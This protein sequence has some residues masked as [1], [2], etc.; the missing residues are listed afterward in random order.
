MNNITYFKTSFFK[1][2][3][4]ILFNR[5][6]FLLQNSGTGYNATSVKTLTEFLTSC[7][8]QLK[9]EDNLFWVSL[10]SNVLADLSDVEK[11]FEN[12]LQEMKE[13]MKE[14]GWILPTLEA[15]MR[16]QVNI[17]NVQIEK[18][19]RYVGEMQASITKLKSGTSLIGEIPILFKVNDWNKKKDKV[20]Q[21][22]IELMSQKSEKN[23]VVLW[24]SPTFEDVANDIKKVIKDKEVVAYPSKKSKEEGISNVQ[25]FIEKIDHIL[26]TRN[27]YFNG[28]ES[29]NVIFLTRGFEGVRNSVLRGVQ[30]IICIQLTFGDYDAKMNGMKEDNRFLSESESE[31]ESYE[32]ESDSV[33]DL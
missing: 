12:A 7:R 5:K 14:N 27:K 8:Q 15:N 19:D 28:C 13:E 33:G 2:Y 1:T 9:H 21:H 11:D 24:D 32:S 6:S 26:V 29:A 31:S 16:N 3:I 23:I 18:S 22:C 10:Q 30:N 25:Q 4:K 20:L 17:A